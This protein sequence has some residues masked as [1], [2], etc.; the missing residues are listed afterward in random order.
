M[1]EPSGLEQAYLLQR[2]VINDTI[3]KAKNEAK[4]LI[5][6]GQKQSERQRIVR[7]RF[8]IRGIINAPLVETIRNGSESCYRLRQMS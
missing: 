2:E 4:Q 8:R 7:Q 3:S 6:A 1:I 5:K